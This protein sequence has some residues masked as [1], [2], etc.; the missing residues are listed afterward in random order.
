MLPKL[1]KG[2]A[3]HSFY[4]FLYSQDFLGVYWENIKNNEHGNGMANVGEITV[5]KGWK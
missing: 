3:S 2:F 5:P 4:A 1:L